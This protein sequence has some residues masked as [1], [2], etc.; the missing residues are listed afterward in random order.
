MESYEFAHS[1]SF[2]FVDPTGNKGLKS[3]LMVLGITI[4]ST[5]SKNRCLDAC[6]IR[7]IICDHL[8]YVLCGMLLKLSQKLFPTPP[9]MVRGIAALMVLHASFRDCYEHGMRGCEDEHL[10]CVARCESDYP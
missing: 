2:K 7:H 3:I 4:W 1:N 10:T 5:D 6:A 8:T 9:P